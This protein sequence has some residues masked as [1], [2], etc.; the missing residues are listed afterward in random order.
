M[1]QD[2]LKSK[3]PL[4][5]FLCFHSPV[6]WFFF[7]PEIKKK[8]LVKQV[9]SVFIPLF[10]VERINQTLFFYFGFWIC[11][12][13]I[14]YYWSYCDYLLFSFSLKCFLC[15]SGIC[16][17]KSFSPESFVQGFALCFIRH[18]HCS[19]NQYSF[20]FHSTQAMYIPKL[21]KHNRYYSMKT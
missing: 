12:N 10:F 19:V 8:K 5:S 1:S 14:I 18:I 3:F 11:I 16:F 7:L 13:Q 21:L 9:A 2:S 4:F 6:Y 20:Q 15:V 17:Y